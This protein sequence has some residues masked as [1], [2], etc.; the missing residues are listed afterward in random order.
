MIIKDTS[1]C[2]TRLTVTK[3]YKNKEL[4]GK[5]MDLFLKLE[6]TEIIP[7]L[8]SYSIDDCSITFEKCIPL[9]D[10]VSKMNKRT[11]LSVAR[12]LHRQLLELNKM[13]Y[14]HGDVHVRNIV[15]SPEYR[16]FLIDWEHFSTTDKKFD[17][18][19]D[20]K[21]FMQ[22]SYP[23]VLCALGIE[24]DELFEHMVKY[25]GRK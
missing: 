5:L 3:I 17:E 14:Q 7:K 16:P 12:M 25:E 20:Y 10:V 15:L 18:C 13:R 19:Y 8:I 21:T 9:E 23:S 4:F 11:R 1:R 6:N 22:W 24:P 2:T